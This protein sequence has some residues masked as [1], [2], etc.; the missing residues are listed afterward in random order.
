MNFLAHFLLA[1]HRD[2]PQFHCGS[3]F[4]DIAK[5][6][7]YSLR[8]GQILRFR[9]LF[10]DLTD[11]IELHWQGDKL[12]HQSE[13]FDFAV[14]SWKSVFENEKLEIPHRRYFLFHLLAEMWLDK[15]LLQEAPDEGKYFYQSL[16]KVSMEEIGEF[17]RLAMKDNNGLIVQTLDHFIQ[18][19]FVLAYPDDAAFGQIAS[20]VFFHVTRQEPRANL[21]ESI[22]DCLKGLAHHENQLIGHW[23][24]F[25]TRFT[26]VKRYFPKRQ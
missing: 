12:F 7:G 11:G 13:L 8:P 21:P 23:K 19:Q 10:P 20:G 4:P 6:S 17:S 2:S 18:R 24:D 3:L 1:K 25:E 15:I 14:E 16:S 26:Q 5:R 22:S 9:P